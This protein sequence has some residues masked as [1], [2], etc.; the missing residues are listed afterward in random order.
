MTSDELW[1]KIKRSLRKG[2]NLKDGAYVV[3]SIDDKRVTLT[4]TATGKPVRATRK[5]I[6]ATADRL[7]SGEEIP[8]RSISYTV[9]IE[10]T[11]IAALTAIDAVSVD[12]ASK[13]YRTK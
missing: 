1:S 5:M 10:F 8:F 12:D 3:E 11:V 4:R 6:E 13:V 7:G 2:R 9:A